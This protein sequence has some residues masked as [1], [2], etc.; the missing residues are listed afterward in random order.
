MRQ[1]CLTAE[2]SHLWHVPEPGMPQFL[3]P[4][5]V[6]DATLHQP[7]GQHEHLK[8]TFLLCALNPRPHRDVV[9][10]QL[11]CAHKGL[12]LLEGLFIAGAGGSQDQARFQLPGPQPPSRFPLCSASF[13]LLASGSGSAL[14]C[15][16]WSTPAK[17]HPGRVC[18]CDWKE[19]ALNGS[20]RPR[21]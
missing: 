19:R 6:D 16:R 8:T 3:L 13:L 2:L 10:T 1:D 15:C 12:F 11:V 18:I 14:F 4:L 20:D 21:L 5:E 17:L 9:E 7:T